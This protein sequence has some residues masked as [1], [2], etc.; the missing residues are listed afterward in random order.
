MY[1]VLHGQQGPAGLG[2]DIGK[3]M[4][5]GKAWSLVAGRCSRSR[6][7]SCHLLRPVGHRMGWVKNKHDTTEGTNRQGTLLD[8]SLTLTQS[9]PWYDRMARSQSFRFLMMGSMQMRR[10]RQ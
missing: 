7:C 8:A 6:A 1:V 5:D 4:G 10:P 3:G 2:E 9:M